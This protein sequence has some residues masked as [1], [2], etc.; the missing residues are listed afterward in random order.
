[1]AF[2]IR[3]TVVLAV[4]LTLG[5]ISGSL[6][7]NDRFIFTSAKTDNIKTVI[8]DAG[9][10]GF[11]GGA[12][13]HDGTVEKD[14]NLKITSFLKEML[15]SAGYRVISTRDTDV[16]TDDVE[17]DTIAIRKKSDLQNRL[18]LMNDYPDGVFV[19]IHLNKFTTSAAKGS[20]V[21]YNGKIEESK[22]LGEAI[23][24]SIVSLLQPENTRVNKKATTS[25]YLLY[26][27]TIPAVLV[28]CGFLSNR[29]ELELLKDTEY[30]KKMAFC[31]FCG[32]M[33]YFET[34]EK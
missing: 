16:S 25:T 33:E 17:T 8:L 27:A 32:I 22:V 21:F 5:I 14:I 15:K 13:A 31:C 4:V 34:K 28:E 1:M 9:H 10:G 3:I 19:S 29:A 30:Q 24:N 11:D 12:V 6:L 26:N 7:L 18:K 2:K 23:Q 20:Q